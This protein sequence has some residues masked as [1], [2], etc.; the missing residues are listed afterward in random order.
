[1][2]PFWLTWWF[3]GLLALAVIG[4][5]YL[6]DHERIKKLRALHGVRT[7]IARNLHED[8]NTTLNNINLLSEM[9][10]IK[11]DKDIQR[12]KDILNK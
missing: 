8:V 11:A 3:L 4:I 5:F 1:M 9:A 6:I 10:R 12:S 2:P 7:A